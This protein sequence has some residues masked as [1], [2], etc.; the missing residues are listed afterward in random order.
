MRSCRAASAA[1]KLPSLSGSD[2]TRTPSV[3]TTVIVLLLALL[4]A[5]GRAVAQEDRTDDLPPDAWREDLTRLG[6]AFPERHLNAFHEMSRTSFETG[7]QRIRERV[8]AWPDPV[9]AVQLARVVNQ[10]GD[11][12]SGIRLFSDTALSFRSYPVKLRVFPDGLYVVAAHRSHAGL[13]GARVTA[14]GDRSADAALAEAAELVARDNGMEALT[15]GPSLLVMP[16]VLAGTGILG[17]SGPAPFSLELEGRARTSQLQPTPGPF[18]LA[19]HSLLDLRDQADDWVRLLGTPGG[20]APLLHRDPTAPFWTVWLGDHSTQYVQ[21]NH[22]TD[23]A[24]ESFAAF[25]RRVLETAAARGAERIVLDLRWCRGGNGYLI[26]PLVL[27][28]LKSEFDAEGR[29]H[30]LIGRRT[31]SAG[32]MLVSELER[33]SHARFVGE[34]TANRPNLYGDNERIVLEHSGLTVRAAYLKWQLRDPRDTREC[35]APHVHAAWTVDDWRRGEDPALRAVL[36]GGSGEDDAEEPDP[37]A[38]RPEG[39]Y[40]VFLCR[41]GGPRTGSMY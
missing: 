6:R 36:E 10:V 18:R 25:S 20:E 41:N 19:G 27:G 9:V 40:A 37:V 39:T 4:A 34:P 32:Q 22:I 11:G 8:G 5:N 7:L 26:R 3:L 17:A 33:L 28:L 23:T 29:L 21:V 24:E 15:F 2:M 35:T 14:I 31:F 38:S 1:P 13:L 30:V 12:H 16:E